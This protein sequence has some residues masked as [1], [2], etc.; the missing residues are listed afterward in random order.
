LHDIPIELLQGQILSTV[1][2]K[3]QEF[4]NDWESLDDKRTM[5]SLPEKLCM[6]E[7]GLQTLMTVAE[8]SVFIARASTTK[9]QSL[10]IKTMS[11]KTSGI[12]KSTK[13]N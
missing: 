5:N 4:S 3:Y 13:D 11:S 6:I 10:A 1:V 9:S 7:K 12:K 2:P 8:S